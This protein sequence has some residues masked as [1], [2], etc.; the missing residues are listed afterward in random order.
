MV[1]AA[2]VAI[3]AAIVT[4]PVLIIRRRKTSVNS[5]VMEIKQ[6]VT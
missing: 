6:L 3:L 1:T 5:K 4:T 2:T